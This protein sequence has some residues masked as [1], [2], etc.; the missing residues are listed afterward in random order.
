MTSDN[1]RRKTP[2]HRADAGQV[3]YLPND[4][5][6][7]QEVDGDGEESAE[8]DD[9]AVALD[10]HAADRPPDEHDDD[11][12]EKGRRTLHLCKYFRHNNL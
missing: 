1:L 6:P 3:E 5:Y 10:D 11:A 9:E 2:T 4:G 7:P 8:E 12:A